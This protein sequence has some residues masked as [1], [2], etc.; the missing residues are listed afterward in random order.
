G[1]HE[2][3]GRQPAGGK[4]GGGRM[5]SR[6]S[7]E[8]ERMAAFASSMPGPSFGFGSILASQIGSFE[9]LGTVKVTSLGPI[10]AVTNVIAP[11]TTSAAPTMPGTTATTSRSM[12][13]NG[14]LS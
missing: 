4:V 5:D 1:G 9:S 3:S 8:I 6:R 14:L 12:S 13:G 11:A 10:S 7:R 2:A